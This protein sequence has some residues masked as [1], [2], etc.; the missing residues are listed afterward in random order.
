MPARLRR[1]ALALGAAQLA[2]FTAVP[3]PAQAERIYIPELEED[4][5]A[6][7]MGSLAAAQREAA[8]GY[9]T[10][11]GFTFTDRQPESGIG[12]LHR[13]VDDVGKH[14]KPNHYD[15]GNSLSVADVD[16]D[17]LEDLYFTSQLGSNGLYRNL[18]GGRFEDITERAGV[19]VPD[20]VSVVGTFGDLDN[21]GDPDLVVTTVKM[22]NLLFRNDGGGRFTDVSASSGLAAVRHSSGVVFFDF[23]R[24]GRLDVFVANVGR[25][26]TDA[27]GRGGAYIGFHDAFVR[28][29]VPG[30]D[31]RSALYRNEGDLRFSDVSQKLG[32]DDP[33]WSGDATFVDFDQ[34]LYPDLYVLNMQG[35]DRY[36]RNV[37]GRRF[38]EVRAR[39]FPKSPWGAMGARFFDFDNDGLLDL[40][41]TDMHSDMPYLQTLEQETKKTELSAAEMRSMQGDDNLFGNAF[42]R[43]LGDGAFEEISDRVGLENYWPW[44]FSVGDLNADGFLDVFVA[45]S[46]SYPYHYAVNKL[47]LNESGTRFVPAEF[48]LGVEPR[49]DGRFYTEWFELDCSGEDADLR[50][51][52][53]RQGRFTVMGTLGTRT[54]VLVDLDQDGDLDIVTSEFNA[55]P[56]V[57][58]SDLSERTELSYLRVRLRGTRSNRDGLGARVVVRTRQGVQTRYHDGASGY[59]S[60][61]S[62]PLYFGLGAARRVER[63]EV[64]WPSGTRQRVGDVDVNTTVEIV[65]PA[66]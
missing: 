4:T 22:G 5:T 23:D 16:G 14:A 48:L 50:L 29:L 9:R 31:E 54:S 65:E 39:H 41:V 6:Q 66:E 55:E 20:R 32:L 42:Y 3:A 11:H 27:K 49:R 13:I 10:F 61:S 63:V 17:G 64:L 28:H 2:F 34:D 60:H 53:E 15:H 38:E 12:F 36:W 45:A 19:G 21:D 43:N 52:E 24:D 18:G 8:A 30:H 56:Q 44:G 26:T 40:Y 25:Y 58:V 57:L 7:A 46:M 51:C 35:D 62:Q 47:M 33:G 37:G 59:L 1:V